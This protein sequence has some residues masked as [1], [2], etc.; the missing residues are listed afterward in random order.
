MNAQLLSF[1]YF[2]AKLLPESRPLS[3]PCHPSQNNMLHGIPL[4]PAPAAASSQLSISAEVDQGSS[5]Y[6][7]PVC[8]FVIGVSGVDFAAKS[9]HSAGCF[10]LFEAHIG[11]DA[12]LSGPSRCCRK[13]WASQSVKSAAKIQRALARDKH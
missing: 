2:N 8:R 11:T 1:S 4:T 7:Y 9:Y 10:E 3:S 13:S 5:S 12:E 6:S